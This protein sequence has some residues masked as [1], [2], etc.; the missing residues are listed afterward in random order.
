VFREHRVLQE[1]K[2]P[3]VIREHRVQQVFKEV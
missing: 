1:Y 3:K 2:A